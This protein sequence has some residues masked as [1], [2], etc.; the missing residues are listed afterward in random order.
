M[1]NKIILIG[2]LTKEAE[3]RYTPNGD[4]VAGFRVACNYKYGERSEVIFLDCSLFGK[5]AE[6]VAPYLTK[7]TLVYVEGRLKEDKWEADG[8]EKRKFS[9]YANFVKLLGGTGNKDAKADIKAPEEHTEL[10][11]F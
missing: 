6:G 2:N 7:G 10:E 9:V 8:V 5:H 1:Y 3:L 4:A 11:A